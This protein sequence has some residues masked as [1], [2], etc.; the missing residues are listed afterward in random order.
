MWEWIDE[1]LCTFRKCFA[2][3]AAFRWFVV[4]VIGFIVRSDSL[5]ITSF[6]RA[7]LIELR[8]YPT[9]LHFFRAGS[10]C[11]ADVRNQWILVVKNT[12]TMFWE[13]S[14]PILVG[15]GVKQSKEGKKMPCVKRLFQ[16]SE[17]SSKPSY[18]YGHMF[19][20]IGVLVGNAEK[21]FC[22]PLS[23]TI[24]DGVKRIGEWT[25]SVEAAESH[26]VQ[27]IR[28]ACKIAS[29]RRLD[30]IKLPFSPIIPLN[31]P[32]IPIIWRKI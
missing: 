26:V 29:K 18:I 13:S 3:E 24:Q 10:W 8:F 30:V 31:R 12:G 1:I 20:A 21:L 4:V 32:Y 23:M 19:G 22:V 7:L 5:G 2:Q 6:I 27:M 9:L 25:E 15:D 14:M 17:N 28:N 11:L 16:E